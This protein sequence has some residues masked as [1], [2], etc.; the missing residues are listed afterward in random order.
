MSSAVLKMKPQGGF[1]QR[2]A[3]G[4]DGEASEPSHHY[5]YLLGFW[6]HSTAG[7]CEDPHTPEDAWST[8]QRLSGPAMLPSWEQHLAQD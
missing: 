1:E 7:S 4:P 6:G 3:K 5:S 2:M 8:K